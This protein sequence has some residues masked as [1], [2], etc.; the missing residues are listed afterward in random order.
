[1]TRWISEF[2]GKPCRIIFKDPSYARAVVFRRPPP[3]G[4]CSVQP[5]TG[6]AD[7]FPIVFFNQP[8][9][10]ETNRRLAEH[11]TKVD[12]FTF[13]PSLVFDL[14]PSI[15]A[16][17][18]TE[19]PPYDEESWGSFE[20]ITSSGESVEF[21][22]T[23]HCERCSM[24]NIDRD[25]GTISK[26]YQPLKTLR[27]FRTPNLERPTKVCFGMQTVPTHPPDTIVSVGDRIK[28]LG[29]CVHYSVKM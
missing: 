3:P 4:T 13:R 17:G 2:L 10:D 12:H 7:E 1:A 26:N 5:T 19:L 18:D 16:A 9:I 21:C 11:G 6:F 8:T 23:S 15:A 25:T 20:L 14:A 27:T 29:R 24:L 28:I 22:V